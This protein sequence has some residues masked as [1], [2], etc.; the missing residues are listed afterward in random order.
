MSENTEQE[1]AALNQQV[2]QLY[3]VGRYEEAIPI[4]EKALEV[5]EQVFGT[6]H[7]NTGNSLSNLGMLY[8]ATGDY[9]RA[10]LLLQRALKNQ[11]KALGP[12][13][14]V[15]AGIVYN[16][17]EL[18]HAIGDYAHA[19]PM[20]Q[21]VLTVLEKVYGRDHVNSTNSLNNLAL[22]YD[23]TGDYAKAELLYQRVLT[24]CERAFGP[25]HPSTATGLNN[26]A[27]HYYKMGKY[28]RAESLY[29][30]SLKI[31]ER[32]L[33]PDHPKTAQTINNLAALYHGQGD[34]RRAELFYQ[35]ALAIVEKIVGPE[36]PDTVACVNN[37][38]ELYRAIG[39]Y[40]HAEPLYQR[41]LKIKEKS[42]GCMHPTIAISLNNLALYYAAEGDYG[43]AEP[44]YQRALKIREKALGPDHPDT[45]T[46]CNNLAE[47]Y[48]SMGNY[49]RAEPLCHRA[50]AIYEKALGPD[51]PNTANSLGNLAELYRALGDYVRAEPL[52][53]RALKIRE[54]TLGPDHIDT[55][56]SLSTLAWLLVARER[57]AE[58]LVLLTQ[59]ARIRDRMFGQICSFGSE[60]QRMAYLALVWPDLHIFLS[61]ILSYLLNSKGAIHSALDLVLRR[62]AI[63]AEVLAVQHDA[64]LGGRY[65]ALEMKL[66]E[67]TDLRMQIVQKTLVAPGPEGP[68]V[69]R[70]VLAE[71]NARK[72]QMESDLAKQ[73][74]ELNLEQKLRLADT[75]AVALQLSE[76]GALLEFVR[77]NVFDFKAVLAKGEPQWKPARYLAFVVPAGKPEAVKM[78]DLGEAEPIDRAI[79]EFRASILA[80]NESARD[81][82]VLGSAVRPTRDATTG[83]G[84]RTALLDPLRDALADCTQLVIAPDGDLAR[85][86]FEVL[87]VDDHTRLVDRYRISY[88]GAGRDLLRFGETPTKTGGSPVVAAD[89]D[90][91]L[92]GTAAGRVTDHALPETPTKPR[93]LLDRMF[94]RKLIEPQ[95]DEA[96]PVAEPDPLPTQAPTEIASLGHHS[97]D[98]DRAHIHFGR[99][100]GTRVEGERIARHLGVE[101]WLDRTALE[102]RLK[103]CRSPR[104]LHLATHGFFLEGQKRDLNEDLRGFGP[105][106]GIGNDAFNRLSAR[107]IENPLL[108]SGLALAGVNTWLH[109][110]TPPEEAEDGI[111]TAEDVTG[112]D[113]LDTELVVLSAC[114]TG[115]G[116]VQVGEGVFGLRRSFVL[117]GAKTLIMSLWKVPDLAT[118]ILMDRLYDNLLNKRLPRDES[119][120]ESQRYL[121]DVTIGEIRKDWLSQDMIERLA[122]GNTGMHKELDTLAKKPDDHR[123]FS[124]PLYWGAFICQGEIAPLGE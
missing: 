3:G 26:L 113:L 114:E 59:A 66:R 48:G 8:V 106:G 83:A 109:H 89:P 101:P 117:A 2:A 96:V 5:S 50:L 108:R 82:G 4:G 93:S 18:Y 122:A 84:L 88:L 111:L 115:L 17:A 57:F 60:K 45:A 13:H 22:L 42:L 78:V 119:L 15:T 86:P 30:R 7:S 97:R 72:E 33:E 39:D 38:A 79:T 1:C 65:P 90:F 110:G 73:I 47:L 77:F 69:Y 41:A 70:K 53:Q 94:H 6:D 54:K 99:L 112:L 104:I 85:L 80:G 31:S 64:V 12:E 10:E 21:R 75:K 11:E 123:P 37:L 20:Y 56:D 121:R 51:H 100:P 44:L 28:T 61:L 58:A 27:A 120:H 9:D 52:Y 68:E 25:D 34:F 81:L 49:V 14:L 118:A 23:A 74:P 98:L 16:L 105:I 29:Q 19:E 87:P 102:A 107:G 116:Q 95:T 46:S 24:I 62:K 43:R 35:R 103:G 40:A 55:A 67:L 92:G 91:D 36:H 32:A 76:S 63:G 124:H 71:W